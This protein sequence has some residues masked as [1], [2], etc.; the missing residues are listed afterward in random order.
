MNIKCLFGLLYKLVW[1]I[2]ILRTEQGMIKMYNGLQKQQPFFLSVLIKILFSRQIFEKYLNI[3][4]HYIQWQQRCFLRMD[5]RDKTINRFSQ[6][7]ERV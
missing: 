3:E 7:C 6:F 4:S 5:R 1:N 2:L